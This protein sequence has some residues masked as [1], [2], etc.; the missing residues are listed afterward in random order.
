[1]T[2]LDRLSEIQPTKDPVNYPNADGKM[3]NPGS[4]KGFS[5]LTPP[6]LPDLNLTNK[7]Y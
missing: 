3:A 7:V 1:M 2:I 6:Q 5:D 4:S